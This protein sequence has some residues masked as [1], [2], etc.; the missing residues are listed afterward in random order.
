MAKR[1]D[2]NEDGWEKATVQQQ[3]GDQRRIAW[4]NASPCDTLKSPADIKP[5]H[6]KMTSCE[7]VAVS[8]W[9]TTQKEQNLPGLNIRRI[10]AL[11]VVLNA[12]LCPLTSTTKWV[13]GTFRIEIL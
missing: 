4:R 1:H 12:V 13:I 11:M 7:K 10:P 8:E 9:R 3:E 6:D 2:T 5:T